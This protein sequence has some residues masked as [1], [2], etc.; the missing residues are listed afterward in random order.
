MFGLEG[1]VGGGALSVERKGLDECEF[2]LFMLL[3][4]GKVGT[5]LLGTKVGYVK[6][7]RLL[8]PTLRSSSRQFGM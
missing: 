5:L 2:A 3:A 4:C 1:G 7:L 6:L 8:R